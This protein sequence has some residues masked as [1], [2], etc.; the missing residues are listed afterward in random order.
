[1]KWVMQRVYY[2]QKS[3]ALSVT[4][5]FVALSFVMLVTFLFIHVHPFRANNNS[6]YVVSWSG[7]AIFSFAF[8]FYLSAVTY[9]TDVNVT[10]S[11]KY[12]VITILC[13][14]GGFTFREIEMFTCTDQDSLFQFHAIFHVLVAVG[15]T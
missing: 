4:N 7:I 8:I 14:A 12:F 2:Y 10:K 15:L 6:K 1:M 9:L 11:F 3:V 13:I 5:A